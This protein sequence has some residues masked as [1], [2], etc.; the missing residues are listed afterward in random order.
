VHF[1]DLQSREY[2]SESVFRVKAERLL[3]AND[4]LTFTVVIPCE[5]IRPKHF[6]IKALPIRFSRQPGFTQMESVSAMP[7]TT[8]GTRYTIFPSPSQAMTTGIFPPLAQESGDCFRSENV[9]TRRA[10][11]SGV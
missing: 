1:R 11:N 7:E 6:P 4:D 8:A 3:I 10:R 9:S 5:S 2:R